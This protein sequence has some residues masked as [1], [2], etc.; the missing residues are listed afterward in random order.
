MGCRVTTAVS[1]ARTTLHSALQTVA[2]MQWW[3][4]HRVIPDQIAAPTIYIDSVEL[5]R[6]PF[7]DATFIVATFPIVMVV[8]GA[9][10]AQVE[11]LDD[12]IAHVWDAA[13]AVGEPSRTRPFS[14][15]AG[16]PS[17]RAHTM[18]VDMPLLARTLCPETLVTVGGTP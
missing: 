7:N 11:T 17:L 2:V 10:R 14:L 1:E 16:G 5:A 3:R 18:D 13:S 4:V 12:M 15:D 9:V 8:D 6:E